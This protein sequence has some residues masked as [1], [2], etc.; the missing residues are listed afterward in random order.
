MITVVLGLGNDCRRDDGLGPAVAREV[1]ARVAADVR[2]SASDGDP[3]RMLDAW[4]G[5]D[6]AVLVDAVVSAPPRPGTVHRFDSNTV[7]ALPTPAVST[8]GLGLVTA[9]ELGSVLDR[10]PCRWVLY[11]VEVLDVGYG[12]GLSPA[13]AGAVES[14]VEAVLSELAGLTGQPA[15]GRSPNAPALDWSNPTA[16]S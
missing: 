7:A 2:V 16:C 13:A 9:L 8:H 1:A 5:A 14:V 6:L 3:T 11:V 4:A 15:V 12:R 10:L